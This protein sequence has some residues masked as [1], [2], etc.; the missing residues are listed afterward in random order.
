MPNDS[1]RT[2]RAVTAETMGVPLASTVIF[3]SAPAGT[4]SVIRPRN[5]FCI[6]DVDGSA[7]SDTSSAR[8]TAWAGPE[9]TS[10]NA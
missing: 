3:V 7:D 10:P 8:I 1:S 2:E 9:T 4:I 6:D 5:W